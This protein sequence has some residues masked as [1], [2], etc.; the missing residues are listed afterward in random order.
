MTY[1]HPR[2][3]RGLVRS[4]AA[5]LIDQGLMIPQGGWDPAEMA[6][7]PQ[8]PLPA[9]AAILIRPEY[10]SYPVLLDLT[11]RL[12]MHLLEI[13]AEQEDVL[14]EWRMQSRDQGMPLPTTV[15]EIEILYRALAN[16]RLIRRTSLVSPWVAWVQL[17]EES[18]LAPAPD[19]ALRAWHMLHAFNGDAAVTELDRALHNEGLLT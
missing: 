15:E 3:T 9:R 18:L 10:L 4:F 14:Y 8:V 11:Q 6:Q 16:T 1:Q 17:C 7:D 13:G 2:V 5:D 12:L 19:L